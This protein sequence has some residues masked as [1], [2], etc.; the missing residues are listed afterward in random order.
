MYALKTKGR[1][2]APNRRDRCQTAAK[3]A[4]NHCHAVTSLEDRPRPQPPV[5]NPGRL[6]HAYGLD[7]QRRRL[8]PDTHRRHQRV[9]TPSAQDGR[10]E[11]LHLR[12][13]TVLDNMTLF[14][15]QGVRGSS[16]LSSTSMIDFEHRTDHFW[17]PYSNASH[18]APRPEH[19]KAFLLLAAR[20]RHRSPSSWRS[21]CAEG[22]V[23]RCGVYIKGVCLRH[24]AKRPGFS[25]A[26]PSS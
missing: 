17:S 2:C 20:P 14:C 18:R 3:L 19:L 4:D 16:P 24:I 10:T 23:W 8:R 7:S 5:D 21:G 26:W 15:K 9:W 6:A 13:A 25:V 12:P 1:R 22:P 11:M